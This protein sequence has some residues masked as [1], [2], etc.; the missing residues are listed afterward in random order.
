M[1]NTTV[2]QRVVGLIA[3]LAVLFLLGQLVELF[4]WLVRGAW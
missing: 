1:T 4:D 2:K 3:F